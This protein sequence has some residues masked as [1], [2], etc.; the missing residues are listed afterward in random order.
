M[1]DIKCV[2][3]IGAGLGGTAAAGLLSRAGFEVRLYEQAPAFARLGAGI[4]VGP[5]VMKIMRR[6]GVEE[7][8]NAVASH[9]DFWFSRDATNGSYMSRIPLGGAANDTRYGAKY[10]TVHRGDFHSIMTDALADGVLRF[11]KKLTSVK[12]NDNSVDVFFED[13][14]SDTVDLLIG[15]DGVNSKIR[16]SL[17]GPEEPIYTGYIGHRCIIPAE[18]LG[19]REFEP[20][21][22]WWTEDRHIMVYYLSDT[23]DELYYVTGVPEP[24]WPG[25]VNWLPSSRA[26]VQKA[27]SGYHPEVQAILDASDTV[28]KWPFFERKPLPLWHRG[29]IV[30]LGDACHPMKPHM[31]QGAAMA[32]EDA[33][34]LVRCLAE[35]K[36]SISDKLSAYSKARIDRA[37]RVQQVS[38]DNTW[39][40]H[41]EDPYWVFGYDPYQVELGA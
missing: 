29:R 7:Q 4:H 37:S 18:R 12:Q 15:G 39:L 25:G 9:P 27:L 35:L 13:G 2:G 40:R 31:G 6:L 8:L 24:D 22:K 10:V 36:G 28:T 33:A 38:H 16:E 11:S 26:E 41:D 23:H 17:L 5:N 32:I 21:V 1:S 19:G 3:V 30:L 20:C 14:S 34:I